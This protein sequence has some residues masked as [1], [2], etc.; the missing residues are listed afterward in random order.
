MELDAG[1]LRLVSPLALGDAIA[2]GVRLVRVSHDLGLR[3]TFEVEGCLLH[4]E[5]AP[6]RGPKVR[7]S[8]P[9]HRHLSALRDA[10][11]T[12]RGAA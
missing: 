8:S 2:P 7:G 1:L 12:E 10:A 6:R 9:R 11:C 4:I 5:L 3:L